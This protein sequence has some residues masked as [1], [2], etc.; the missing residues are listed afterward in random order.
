MTIETETSDGG[1]CVVKLAGRMDAQGTQE[2]D[3]KFMDYACA[4]RAVIV[5]MHA[6]DFLASMGIRT[7]VMVAKAVSKRGGKMVLL[8]PDANIAK[9]LE[10]SGIDSFIPIH[11]SMDDARRAV[12]L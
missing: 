11:R 10:I 12:S 9:I 2:I 4:Q 5:D 8:N 6:V 1:I 3:L 7:L